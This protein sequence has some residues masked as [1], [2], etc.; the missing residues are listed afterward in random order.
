MIF[1]IGLMGGL[2]VVK[3][4]CVNRKRSFYKLL[5]SRYGVEPASALFIDD[6]LRNIQAGRG[7]GYQTILFESPG[8]LKD[9]LVR[10]GLL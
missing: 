8:Q 7:F 10:F 2:S 4:I 1:S 6:N 5:E 3:K 9:E